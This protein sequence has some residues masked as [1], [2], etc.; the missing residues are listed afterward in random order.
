MYILSEKFFSTALAAFF[1]RIKTPQL[2]CT[3]YVCMYVCVCVC[4]CVCVRTCV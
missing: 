2:F 3:L 4:V 1:F